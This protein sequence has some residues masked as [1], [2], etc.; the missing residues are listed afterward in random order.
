MGSSTLDSAAVNSGFRAVQRRLAEALDRNAPGDG[1][2]GPTLEVQRPGT[3][4]PA[5]FARSTMIEGQSLVRRTVPG[6]RQVGFDAFLDG[7]QSSRVLLHDAAIPIVHGSVG[8][9]VRVRHERRLSTWQHLSEAR[10][11]APRGLLGSATNGMLDSLDVAVVDTT[12]RRDDGAV[13]EDAQHPLMLADIAVHAV[14]GHRETLEQ[15]LADSWAGAGEDILFMDGGISGDARVAA[16]PNIVGVVKSHRVLYGD[17]TAVRT[18]L[19]LV[20]GERS[21][22]FTIGLPERRRAPVASW[23]LRLRDAAGRDPLWGMVRVEIAPPTGAD[24]SKVGARADEVSR[25][26]LAEVA[27]LSLPDSRWDT[28]VYGIRDCE[29]FLRAIG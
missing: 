25:W 29:Q 7:V 24:A 5:R 11:Y 23:Y 6:D 2:G 15:R 27:P 22:V 18:I 9:V 3:T 19:S 13:D 12:P 21:T 10:V 1:S 14:Q 26:I 20:E 16:A 17:T 28:M 4:E 8:A